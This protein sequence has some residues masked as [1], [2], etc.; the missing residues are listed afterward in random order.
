MTDPVSTRDL[1]L[2]L[3]AALDGELDAMS[4]LDLERRLAEDPD[5]RRQYEALK[6]LQSAVRTHAP[7]QPA[8]ASLRRAIERMAPSAQARRQPW[9]RGFAPQ[10]LAASLALVAAF[11]VGRLS[12]GWQSSQ[13]PVEVALADDFMRAQI[14]GSTVDVA[15]SDRHTVKPWLATRAPLGSVAVDLSA[16][17][18][19][20]IGGRVDLVDQ[21]ALPTL[22]YRAREHLIA[23]T[24]LPADVE[25]AGA[26]PA[27]SSVAG[28]AVMRWRD[29]M[30]AYVAISDIAP[31]DLG[32]FVAK[33]RA[34]SAA[35]S[36]R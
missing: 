34:A 24:E 19:P 23:V 18:V 17:G 20:L 36:G 30:R 7:R 13:R 26:T 31:A 6:A 21:R 11:G 28:L 10:A 15:S 32:D 27:A 8:P 29:G 4:L 25:G 35:E 3:Q 16:D 5:L 1:R 14:S 9:M 22:V 2:R 12:T 33:F